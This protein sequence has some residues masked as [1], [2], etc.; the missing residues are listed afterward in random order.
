MSAVGKTH[1][2]AKKRKDAPTPG[3]RPP[4]FGQ[5]DLLLSG[6][7]LLA[8][9]TTGAVNAQAQQPKSS[10]ASSGR[11]REA[12]IPVTWVTTSAPWNISHNNRATP[13]Q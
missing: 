5:I 6:G 3:P 7:S 1:V 9:S 4:E 10:T 2:M 11:S 13:E 8:L 12:N